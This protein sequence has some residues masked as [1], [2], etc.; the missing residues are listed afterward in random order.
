MRGRKYKPHWRRSMSGLYLHALASRLAGMLRM[1]TNRA[2]AVV[3]QVFALEAFRSFFVPS[4]LL[5]KTVA[6][7]LSADS[8][9][10]R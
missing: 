5:Q 10:S 6:S 3:T 7:V 2:A 9:I 8:S 1:P 4:F